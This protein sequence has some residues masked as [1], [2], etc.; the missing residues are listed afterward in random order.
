MNTCGGCDSTWASLN[1]AHC[2]ATDCHRTFS[3]IGYF[4]LHR[5]GGVC[6][7]PAGITREDGKAVLRL[8]DRGIWVGAEKRPAWWEDKAPEKVG[9]S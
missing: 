4:D 3:G 1:Y 6:A 7:D 2:A 8:D 5:R 9:K